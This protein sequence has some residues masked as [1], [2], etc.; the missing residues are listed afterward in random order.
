[1]LWRALDLLM[2]LY[3][4]LFRA[5]S[6][7]PHT[8]N[9]R[10]NLYVCMCACMY[11]YTYVCVCVYIHKHRTIYILLYVFIYSY[12]IYVCMCVLWIAEKSFVVSLA[13]CHASMQAKKYDSLI[14]LPFPP[15]LVLIEFIVKG[16]KGCISGY[17]CYLWCGGKK[18]CSK[19]I[20]LE[21]A[22]EDLFHAD[23]ITSAR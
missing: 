21:H 15:C 14:L 23:S 1:M 3:F 17:I 12:T 5:E 9:P 7:C 13:R 10:T 2:P 20:G 19:R 18:T 6:I 8:S 4:V 22:I 11:L 16:F